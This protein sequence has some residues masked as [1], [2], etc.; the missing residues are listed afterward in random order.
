MHF[1][2]KLARLQQVIT[3]LSSLL[4]LMSIDFMVDSHCA[5]VNNNELLLDRMTQPDPKSPLAHVMSS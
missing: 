4:Q 1:Y 3:A 2:C 5:E